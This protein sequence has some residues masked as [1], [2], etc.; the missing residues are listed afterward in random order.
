M[1]Q[2]KTYDC[3]STLFIIVFFVTLTAFIFSSTKSISFAQAP[4]IERSNNME[5]NY[6]PESD[7]VTVTNTISYKINDAQVYYD[8]N[9]K[10]TFLV[11]DYK[12]KP[13]AT[14]RSFKKSTLTISDS[15]NNNI[16]DYTI[17][18]KLEG[19]EL[20]IGRNRQITSFSPYEVKIQYKT[21]ELLSIKGNITSIFIPGISKDQEFQNTDSGIVT[22][23]SF[24]VKVIV[25]ESTSPASEI[26][27][28]SIKEEFANQKKIYSINGSDLIGKMG[29][30][31]F[32]TQ[33]Y[34]YFK[35][36]QTAP[37]TDYIIPLE[38]SK[39]T[40]LLSTNIFKIV[41]PRDYS[42]TNQKVYYKNITPKPTKIETDIEGNIVATFEV[43]ANETTEIVAE[44]YISI[45]K[46]NRTNS[47]L[48]LP[49][50]LTS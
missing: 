22:Q 35:I 20:K 47:E 40:N 3:F 17:A 24:N 5:I 34:N 23:L 33:Q 31:Q 27:P 9:T 41:L 50:M 19:I 42:E 38:L 48:L 25:P 46:V 13:D 2:K 8:A 4:D 7:F 26:S 44:G 15:D 12:M 39:L 45:E 29:W 18:E 32:G 43:P 6:S 14:E 28:S 11:Q 16:T 37:K 10:L 49:D 21:H 30:I 36:V 1:Y